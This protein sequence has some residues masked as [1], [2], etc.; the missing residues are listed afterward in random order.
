MYSI[1]SKL[2]IIKFVNYS[3]IDLTFKFAIPFALQKVAQ[4][5]L[6]ERSGK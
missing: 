2:L 5:T 1:D 4:A 6:T 3:P